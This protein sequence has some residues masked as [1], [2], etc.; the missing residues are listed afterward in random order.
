MWAF[1]IS[2]ADRC[3]VERD[4]ERGPVKKGQG[5]AHGT[6]PQALLLTPCLVYLV[7][8][9]DVTSTESWV[10]LFAYLL[11]FYQLCSN[12]VFGIGPVFWCLEHN[13]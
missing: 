9:R 11:A 4:W 12:K 1:P 5:E 13:R 3:S 10:S 6:T 2:R 7:Q 8:W